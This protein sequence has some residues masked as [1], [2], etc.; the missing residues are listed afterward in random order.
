[1]PELP[2]VETYKRYLDDTSLKQIISSIKVND[3][4]VL[5][6][7]KKEIVRSLEGKKFDKSNR[8]GKY[9]FVDLDSN[10]IVMHFGMSGDLEYYDFS[11]EEPPYSKVLFIFANGN[12]LSYISIRMFGWIDI[13]DDM[14]AYIKKIG[15]GPDAYK[16]NFDDFQK[17]LEGRSAYLK[18][19]LLNQD[20][21][22]GIGNIYSDEILFQAGLHPKRKA[23]TL[24]D[25]EIKLL[26]N[27][28]K[29]I[30]EFGIKMK[31]DLSSYPDEYL[32]SH[33]RDDQICPACGSEIQRIS[34]SS[35]HGYFCP[36]CQDLS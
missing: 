21:L 11:E 2:E 8:H 29:E 4:R 17:A 13:T 35:R 34:I 18:S 9:L 22:A 31:G 10:C 1:M 33:R 36:K 28:I 3:E 14:D 19:L 16:M 27:K 25:K 32:I 12:A 26:F 24:D 23:N 15:L 20:V 5:K 30:L 6:T 7:E